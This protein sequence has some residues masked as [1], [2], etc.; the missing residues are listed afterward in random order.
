MTEPKAIF[1]NLDDLLAS[2][3]DDEV[4]EENITGN[5]KMKFAELISRDD[6]H[7]GTWSC[8]PCDWQVDFHE[9]NE[10]M[11]VL[12]GRVRI[13]N[14]DGSAKELTKGDVFFIPRG[15]SG[16]WE[17]LETMEK[18]YVIIDWEAS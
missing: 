1:G 12:S 9:E 2:M 14:A 11:L 6:L 3:V 5:P 16:R 10:V 15:W 17:T 13:T 7:V 18:L 4:P 8:T